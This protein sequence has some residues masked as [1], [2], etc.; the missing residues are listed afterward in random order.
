V[1]IPIPSLDRPRGFG[2]LFPRQYRARR[3]FFLKNE[4]RAILIRGGLSVGSR[5][6]LGD[7]ADKK[8]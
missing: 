1:K 7:L 2:W 6:S 5:G 8:F 3:F 4:I